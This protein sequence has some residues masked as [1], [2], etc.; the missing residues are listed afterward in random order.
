MYFQLRRDARQWYS[1]IESSFPTNFDL[2][3]L[4]AMAGFAARRKSDVEPNLVTDLVDYFPK[5]FK[6]R[7]SL[8]ISLLIST[9]LTVAGINYDER[10]SVNRTIA[11]LITPSAESHLTDDGTRLMNR[12][13]HGGFEAL[14]E[15]FEDRPRTIETFLRTYRNALTRLRA[16]ATPTAA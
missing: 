12:Y 14:V 1:D 2:F 3:Y 15:Q 9:E 7:G 16:E 10:D 8:I 4:N 11:R 13:A 6:S 5:D